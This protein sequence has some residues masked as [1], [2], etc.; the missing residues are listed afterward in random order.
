MEQIADEL[1]HSLTSR[2][3]DMTSEFLLEVLATM[4]QCNVGSTAFSDLLAQLLAQKGTTD[5]DPAD[6]AG[7]KLDRSS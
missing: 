6:P 1:L 4:K 3:K 7:L 2:L 5:I